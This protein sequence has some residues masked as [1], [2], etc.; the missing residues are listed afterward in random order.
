MTALLEELG[1]VVFFLLVLAF[2]GWVPIARD[3]APDWFVL[4]GMLFWLYV[5]L[6]VGH[7]L[8]EKEKEK[9]WSELAE[10][11]G[12]TYERSSF[13][14]FSI[15][16]VVGTY[17]NRQVILYTY[18]QHRS[19]YSYTCVVVFINNS[20]NIHFELRGP[21]RRNGGLFSRFTRK[22]SNSD[23][24]QIGDAEF[25]DRFIL[26]GHPQSL[27]VNALGSFSLRCKL[28]QIGSPKSAAT[29]KVD[30]K[31]LHFEQGGILKDVDYLQI[32]FGVLS[33]L[34][35]GIEYAHQ[36]RLAALHR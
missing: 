14:L 6:L 3:F 5:A 30:G 19:V 15:V 31:K 2:F 35:E 12:L 9:P 25:D 23:D 1:V 10:R 18:D 29:I 34:A 8:I 20:A 17:R 16:R 28:L 27:V 7:F 21:H 11:T 26:Q 36:P 4:I 13:F 33:E 24:I 32:L 22:P